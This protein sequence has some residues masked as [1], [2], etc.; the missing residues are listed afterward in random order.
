M[1]IVDKWLGLFYNNY[2]LIGLSGLELYFIFII[3]YFNEKVGNDLFIVVCI[4]VGVF[5]VMFKNL[6]VDRVN[7]M[8]RNC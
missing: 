2:V 3:L 1:N 5:V 7:Y 8:V 4:L 6:I